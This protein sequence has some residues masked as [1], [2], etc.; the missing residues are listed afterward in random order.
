[1]TEG[2]YIAEA[3]TFLIETVIELYILAV[4]LRFL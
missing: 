4:M 3:M 2:S 1:M